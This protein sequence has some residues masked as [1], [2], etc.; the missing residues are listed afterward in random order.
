MD[1]MMVARMDAVISGIVELLEG[2]YHIVRPYDGSMQV[3]KEELMRLR[4]CYCTFAGAPSW[5]ILQGCGSTSLP[6]ITEVLE[7]LEHAEQ[8]IFIYVEFNGINGDDLLLLKA[9]TKRLKDVCPAYRYEKSAPCEDK[10]QAIFTL[11]MN[12]TG[13]AMVEL[14]KQLMYLQKGFRIVGAVPSNEISGPD[15][16]WLS[17]TRQLFHD[18]DNLVDTSRDSSNAPLQITDVEIKKITER[19]S[20]QVQLLS[21]VKGSRIRALYKHEQET[22]VVGADG[23]RDE[24]LKMLAEEDGVPEKNMK[25]VIIVGTEGSGKTTLA[26]LIYSHLKPQFDCAAFV[27]ASTFSVSDDGPWEFF[28]EMA[29][30]LHPGRSIEKITEFLQNK[31]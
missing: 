5:Y 10:E 4:A 19:A 22:E 7:M 3:V 14:K 1:P 18:A 20:L 26:R 17:Q 2:G 6:R 9:L 21:V 13:A 23:P 12:H 16:V 31:R 27:T 30:Q 24:L 15:I 28:E 8:F 25:G 29:S 11:P